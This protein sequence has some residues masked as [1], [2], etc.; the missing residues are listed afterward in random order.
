MKIY[1]LKT[2]T[3]YIFLIGSFT[4]CVDDEIIPENAQRLENKS[5]VS[6]SVSI[7][8]GSV[9]LNKNLPLGVIDKIDSNKH[10]KFVYDLWKEV[11]T[12]IATYNASIDS[13][14]YEIEIS[15][16]LDTT[17]SMGSDWLPLYASSKNADEFVWN[18]T[19]YQAKF[20]QSLS[21]SG[22]IVEVGADSQN[23]YV[24]WYQWFHDFWGRGSFLLMTE[25][26][27]SL[28]EQEGSMV[29]SY[30]VNDAL[31]TGHSTSWKIEP[32]RLLY[33][34][35]GPDQCARDNGIRSIQFEEPHHSGGF[36]I[37]IGAEGNGTL[38][39]SDDC[40]DR[41]FWDESGKGVLEHR[42]MKSYFTEPY[43]RC[44]METVQW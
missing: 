9:I 5:Q 33:E 25:L 10:A 28:D 3:L 11:Q 31:C 18:T 8:F 17:N 29:F 43:E 20:F 44:A 19:D 7:E 34:F 6:E 12:R 30:S 36:I 37:E 26:K 2:L 24:I 27:Q 23:H 21:H 1:K 16:V 39:Y 40:S 35:T 41:Y 38:T 13:I 22:G 42:E 4:S 32:N 15:A 14:L